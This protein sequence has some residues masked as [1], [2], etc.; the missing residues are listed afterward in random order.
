MKVLLYL[1]SKKGNIANNVNCLLW[2]RKHKMR[3][4][5]VQPKSKAT[6]QL[7]SE[8]T[9]WKVTLMATYYCCGQILKI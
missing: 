8:R 6:R 7:G 4:G 2:F 1:H 5:Q 9:S 3:K